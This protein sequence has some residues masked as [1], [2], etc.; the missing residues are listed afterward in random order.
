MSNGAIINAE[1][2]VV[3]TVNGW[4][5]AGTLAAGETFV[6][7]ADLS[8]VAVG[9]PVSAA[10][11]AASDYE[12]SRGLEDVVLALLNKGTLAHADLPPALL[13]KMNAR[14]ALRNEGTI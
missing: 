9:S 3:A 4:T 2:T 7:V 5:G 12:M 1:G 6:A 14:R 10:Q 13:A 11:L 8:L